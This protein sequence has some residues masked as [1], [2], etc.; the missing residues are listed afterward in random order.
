LIAVDDIFLDQIVE[1]RTVLKEE[2]RVVLNQDVLMTFR[3]GKVLL[4]DI[5]LIGERRKV[6][7]SLDVLEPG[8]VPR[9]VESIKL[10]EST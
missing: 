2:M 5:G 8:P 9:R 4:F 10:T 1:F 7:F 3:K 6:V